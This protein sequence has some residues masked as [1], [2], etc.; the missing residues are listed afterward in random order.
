[1][2]VPNNQIQHNGM[3]RMRAFNGIEENNKSI[4]KQ[5]KWNHFYKL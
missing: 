1:M 2:K 4:K 3:I 5:W